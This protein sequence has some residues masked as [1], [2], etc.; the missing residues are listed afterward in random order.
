MNSPTHYIVYGSDEALQGR[1]PAKCFTCHSASQALAVAYKHQVDPA[2]HIFHNM[3]DRHTVFFNSLDSL[4]CDVLRSPASHFVLGHDDHEGQVE[5]LCDLTRA[6]ALSWILAHADEFD[7]MTYVFNY[8]TLMGC[9]RIGNL[10]ET[11]MLKESKG[12]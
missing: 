12:S 11:Y 7:M 5:T 8:K 9:Y 3:G 4:C 1:E 10:A 6:E 2:T